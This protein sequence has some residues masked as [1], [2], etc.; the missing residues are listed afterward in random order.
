MC[1]MIGGLLSYIYLNLGVQGTKIWMEKS[2]MS[3]VIE[4]IIVGLLLGWIVGLVWWMRTA[5]RHFSRN[6]RKL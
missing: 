3:F 2:G 6:R 5:G 1:T 4:V